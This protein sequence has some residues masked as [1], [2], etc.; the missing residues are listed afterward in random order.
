[1]PKLSAGSIFLSAALFV[2]GCFPEDKTDLQ[3]TALKT[4]L[5]VGETVQLAVI[6]KLPDGS[7]RELTSPDTGTTYYTRVSPG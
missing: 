2:S 6:Q 1:M 3:V 7:I 4:T 5:R